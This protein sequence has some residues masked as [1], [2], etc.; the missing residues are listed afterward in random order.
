MVIKSDLKGHSIPPPP[1]IAAQGQEMTPKITEL[2]LLADLPHGSHPCTRTQPSSS[3]LCGHHVYIGTPSPEDG[4]GLLRRP[5][6]VGKAAT[7]W[8]HGGLGSEQG[9]PGPIF[10]PCPSPS[11]L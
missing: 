6:K 7:W 9:Y 5:G 10:A 11:P 4:W 2:S 1:A 8:Q 3:L